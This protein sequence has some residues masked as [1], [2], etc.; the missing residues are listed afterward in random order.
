MLYAR[1]DV[2]SIAIPSEHGGCNQQHSRPVI[3]GAPVKLWELDCPP[4][5]RY[6]RGERKPQKLIYETDP[7]TGAVL[8]QARV[9]D[10]DP[11]WSSTPDTIPLSPDQERTHHIKIERGEQQL[12]ALESIATLAKA[13]IDFRNRPDVLFFLREN[14]LPEDILQG[15]VLC[16]NDHPNASGTKFCG[17]CGV[18][19]AA[20]GAIG[21][22]EPEPEEPAVDLA[23]L[24][25]QTLRKMCR[26]RGLADRGSK[27]EL[28]QRLAA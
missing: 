6:L 20:R 16:V 28:I 15:S 22:S 11:M 1:G 10:S 27:D 17:E 25:P 21:N 7:K 8:R 9:P 19:M 3:K 5:E 13:G 26:D 24:H 12:R 23:R 4:C 2:M 18:S 14:Q